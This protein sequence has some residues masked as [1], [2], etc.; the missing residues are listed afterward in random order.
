MRVYIK[1]V[2]SLL[3]IVA[4]S[5]S[6]NVTKY[7]QEGQ[8]LVTKNS[9]SIVYPDSL[10]RRFKVPKSAPL[11]YIPLSQTPN[12]RVI[13]VDFRTWLYYQSNPQKNNWWN[14]TLRKLGQ[15]PILYDLEESDKSV[16]N[17]KIYMASEGYLNNEIT[18]DAEFARKRAKI[19]YN[20]K[21]N[22]PYFIDSVIYNF[23]D[24]GI[25]KI[26]MDSMAKSLIQKGSILSRP[27]MEQERKRIQDALANRGYYTFRQSNIT[28]LID[29]FKNTQSAIVQINFLEDEVNDK[30]L[31]HKTYRIKQVSVYPD[32]S[33]NMIGQN[34]V[35]DTVQINNIDYLYSGDKEN[36]L[37]KF[38]DRQIMFGVDSIWSPYY[39]NLTVRNFMNMKYYRSAVVDYQNL[40][41][42]DSTSQ[43][44]ALAAHIR[45]TPS[46]LHGIS[47]DMEVSSNANYSSIL[48]SIG[49]SNRNL[50]RHSEYFDIS[51]DAGYDLFYSRS[52]NDAYQLGVQSSLSFPKLIVP[53][54]VNKN[55]FINNIESK[56]SASYDLRNRPD[57]K[58]HMLTTAFGYSWSNGSRLQFN[59]NPISLTYVGLPWVDEDFLNSMTN[60]YLRN[61]YTD[62]LIAGTTFG[63]VFNDLKV[64]GS[65]H[66]VKLNAE[67]AGNTLSLGYSLFNAKSST[68]SLGEQH[69]T[70]LG[71]RYAQY[72]RVDIDYS[73]KYNFTPKSALVARL[74]AGGGLGYDN[75]VTMPFERLFYAGGNASMRGWQIRDVGLGEQPH[76]QNN[77][78]FPNQLGDIRL[79]A[80]LEGRFPIWGMVRGAVFFD[81]GN[82]WSN[83][84]GETDDRAVFHFDKFYKQLAFNTGVGIRLDLSFFVLRLDWGIR[85]HDPSLAEGQRW[86]SG[87][88]FDNTALHF[89]IGYP[90]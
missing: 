78:G 43:T 9:I 36:V 62:Q 18:L 82:V 23:E 12:T 40:S 86:I 37:A 89:A 27:D 33:S 88:D 38:L 4:I 76:P 16:E 29:T 66:T 7:V 41:A 50:F 72:A 32:Y 1:I 44:G 81:L 5:P 87:F 65:N 14:N 21:A 71:I 17:M 10:E 25:E 11:E 8:Y 46:K 63:V 31:P 24:K 79:E 26:V 3:L 74:Y 28:Y 69:N 64:I 90:F 51:L 2:L 49:Y 47:A 61:S 68:S 35:F 13:G 15:E 80:N 57:Y 55:R 77:D 60:P 56:I 83:G 39:Q 54:R 20:I 48:T 84:K 58:R 67:T 52:S 45:L 59:Y 34:V 75:S 85:L 6:C 42:N 53:F 19:T 70:V 73:Y 30:P 22:E